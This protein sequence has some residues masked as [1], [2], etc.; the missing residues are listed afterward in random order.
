M[1]GSPRIEYQPAL[2]GVRALA[3]AVVLLFHGGVPGFGAGYLG[4]SVFFTLSG[5]LIT[6]LLFEEH[7]ATGRIDL[8]AFYGRRLRRLLPASVVTL[9]AIAALAAATDLFAGVSGLRRQVV[10]SLLQIV[11]WVFLAEEGSYQDRLEGAAGAVSPLEHFWSLAIEEQFYWVWPVTVL[12]LFRTVRTARGRVVAIGALTVAAAAA[13]PVVAAVWGGDAAYWATPARLSEI[14]VGAF[15]AVVLAGRTLGRRWQ[16]AAIAALATLGVFVTAFP[17]SDVAAG[18]SLLPVVAAV[19]GLLLIGLQSA[20]PLTSLLSLGPLVW[21]GRIS[22]GVYLF[23][24]PIFVAV[25]AERTGFDGAPLLGVRVAL[26]LAVAQ[27]SFVVLEQ[28]IRRVGGH[29]SVPTFAGASFATAGALAL[30]FAVVPGADSDYWQIDDE[31]A[32]AAAIEVDD[33]PLTGR[34]T[35]ASGDTISTVPPGSAPISLPP[36]EVAPPSTATGV[37]T[38]DTPPPTPAPSATDPTTD[39]TTLPTAAPTTPSSTAPD[40]APG[41]TPTTAPIPELNRPVRVVVAGDSTAEALGAGVVTWAADHPE[42][43]Q[44]EVVAAPGCGIVRGGERRQGDGFEE[45]GDCDRWVS[46]FLLPA[47]E[48]TRPDVVLVMVTSWDLS[49]RRWDGGEALHPTD[50]EF[51]RHLDDDYRTLVDDLVDRGA[52]RVAFVRPPEP[53]PF[54]LERPDP[55]DDAAR[56]GALA[57]T[58]DAIVAERSDVSLVPLADWFTDVGHAT[59]RDMRPD[60]VHLS[61]VAAESVTVDWLGEQLIRIALGLP[62]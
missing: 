6:L 27:A 3:V 49:D 35:G 46:D 15:L 21:L 10:G 39:S 25:D 20:G 16:V 54:W 37:A 38:G 12:V 33:A 45:P 2:D 48:R 19:S 47:V 23:H 59:D 17:A 18:S 9:T 1:R 50:P 51:R 58:H 28:P 36:I 52:A 31:L 14:L 29:R 44:A 8:G 4:V 56:F 32:T 5:F 13:A 55:A 60:G 30:A 53:R 57:A 7:R 24:W 11:N 62:R 42:L 40:V 61:R 43:V 41:A 26:T 22:Y 34:P